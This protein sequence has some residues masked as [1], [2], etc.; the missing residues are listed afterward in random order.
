VFTIHRI[1]YDIRV[2]E[3]CH[4][5]WELC[6]E[7]QISPQYLILLIRNIAKDK[8]KVFTR[9]FNQEAQL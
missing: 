9:L 8:E 6:A 5:I 7:Y 4:H 2:V 3:S 1:E